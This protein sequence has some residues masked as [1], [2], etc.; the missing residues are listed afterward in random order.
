MRGLSHKIHI[1]KRLINEGG[2]LTA[3]DFHYISNA[4]QYFCDLV[5]MKILKNRWGYKG[6][7]KMKFRSIDD[8]EKALKFIGKNSNSDA[9]K[10]KG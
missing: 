3:T 8:Q 1:V 6:D 2:E 7:A 4:N 10:E 5:E 9:E